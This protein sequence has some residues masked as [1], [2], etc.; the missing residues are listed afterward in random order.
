MACF[1]QFIHIGGVMMRV[2]AVH[3]MFG[4]VYLYRW[5]NDES[6]TTTWYV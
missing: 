6:A 2:Q 5:C 3:G 4:A 1:M